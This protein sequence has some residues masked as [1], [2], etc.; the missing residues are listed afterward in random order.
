MGLG[1]SPL[2]HVT[3]ISLAE[4]SVAV[5]RNNLTRLESRP[6]VISN[7]LI[8]EVRANGSLHLSEPVQDFLVGE[9]VERTSKTIET[10][11]ERQHGGAES[12]A[13]QVGGVSADVS[14]LVISVDGEIE[15]HQLNEILVISETKLVGEVET[16]ILILL[17][18]SDLSAL[19]D[20]L[21]DACSDRRKLG[22]QVH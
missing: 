8:A 6:K 7:S 19:E 10:S 14:S 9:T 21:V 22:D 15:S 13:N 3:R 5:S 17:D 1:E 16:V 18:S 4:N 11:S 2:S 20:I 12:T